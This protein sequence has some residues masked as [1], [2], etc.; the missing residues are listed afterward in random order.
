MVVELRG[1]YSGDVVPEK[2]RG[3]ASRGGRHEGGNEGQV[4]MTWHSK[5]RGR[6]RRKRQRD[7]GGCFRWCGT[8][9]NVAKG[10]LEAIGVKWGRGVQGDGPRRL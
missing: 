10:R 4:E 3:I 9:E 6:G 8:L 7:S 1:G 5:F 2:T